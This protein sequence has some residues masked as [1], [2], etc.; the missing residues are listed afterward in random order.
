MSP[1]IPANVV[2]NNTF[3]VE[4]TTTYLE[5]SL[6]FLIIGGIGIISNLFAICILGSST[7]LRQKLVNTLI[8]HQSFVDLLASIALVGMAHLDGGDPHGLEG[9]HAEVY[10][11]FIMTK[12]P[13]WLMM[14]V[15]SFSLIFINIERYISIVFP[16]HHHTKV[17]RKRVLIFLPITWILGILEQTWICS[18]FSAQKGTCAFNDLEMYGITVIA[19]LVLHFFLPIILVLFLYGHMFIRLKSSVKSGND[20]TSSNRNDVMEKAKNN[21]FKTMLL[22]T[23]CYAVCYVFN[24]VYVTLVSR[25][26]L[27]TLSGKCVLHCYCFTR[28]MNYEWNHPVEISWTRDYNLKGFK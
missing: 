7:K 27:K 24:S 3:Q 6:G 16:I 9:F 25:G 19:Y 8:I 15:S 5:R 13:L 10:C 26:I 18:C 21:V 14:D 20:S 28:S 22:I 4:D 17:T 12:F 1:S 11:F 2:S 23:V